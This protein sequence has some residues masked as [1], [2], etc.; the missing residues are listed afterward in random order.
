M[1]TASVLLLMLTS[2]DKL[3]HVVLTAPLHLMPLNDQ[4]GL[5][6]NKPEVVE[7]LIDMVTNEE[8]RGV[9]KTILEI[10]HIHAALIY[11]PQPTDEAV[12]VDQAKDCEQ[13]CEDCDCEKAEQPATLNV[14]SVMDKQESK[15][16]V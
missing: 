15:S 5:D 10:R 7:T 1:P 3:I 8:T 4:G 14:D 13:A 2:S 11:N 12:N 6:I 9:I 16:E